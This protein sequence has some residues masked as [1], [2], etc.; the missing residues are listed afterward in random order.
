MSQQIAIML[1]IDIEAALKTRKL[2][3]NI[4]MFDNLR[5][6]GSIGEGTGELTTIANGYYWSDGSQASDVVFNWLISGVGSL[7]KTLPA[8]YRKSRRKSHNNKIL[9]E[10]MLL[11]NKQYDNNLSEN[12]AFKFLG[13]MPSFSS[14]VNDFLGNSY[15]YGSGSLTITGKDYTKDTVDEPIS[16]LEPVITN[17]TGEAVDKGVIFPAQYG[18]PVP[19]KDG[20][21][22]SATT[23]T[24]KVGTYSY[25]LHIIL[26]KPKDEKHGVLEWEPVEMTCEAKIKVTKTAKVNGFTNGAMGQL[27]IY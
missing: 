7:P 27:P 17:I 15:D 6:E 1:V 5:T 14:K 2:D 19:V 25:T 16:Y 4:Y 24:N 20:W 18:S 8:Q 3:G 9:K 23:D 10:L 13:D 22:W 11:K 21:Y 12:E 26:Y